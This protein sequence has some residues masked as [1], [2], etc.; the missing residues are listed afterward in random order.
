MD[1]INALKKAV[2]HF[3]RI[4]VALIPLGFLGIF[5]FYPLAGIFF[6]SF[7]QNHGF[8]LASFMDLTGSER[9]AGII[10]FTL[11]Q[12]GVSTILTLAFALPCAYVMANYSFRAKKLIMVI[13]SIPFVLPTI[14]VAAA[15][16]ALIGDRG[17]V[18]GIHLEHSIAMIFLAHVFYNFSVVLR[19]TTGFWSFLQHQISEAASVLGASPFQVFLKITLPLLRPAI[20]ASAILVFIFCFSSFGVIL[21]LGGPGFSTVEVEIYRQAA[22]RFNL[23]A[24]AILSLFQICFTFGMMWLYTLLQKKIPTFTPQGEFQ[25][26]KL[27]HTLVAKIMVLA[28]VCFILLFCLGPM[29]ALIIK[30]FGF[31]GRFSLAFYQELFQ[32]TSG[33]LF[34]VSPVKAVS[35]SLLFAVATLAMAV[36]V[37]VCAALTIQKN[38]NRLGSILDPVFMLPLSTSAVT[39][40][41]GIIITLDRPPLNLR[42]SV[43]LVPIAH[44][45]VAFPFVVRSVLPAV[46]SIPDSLREAA[47]LLG[48]TAARVWF[49]V[50]LPIMARAVTA[51]A[52]FAFTM[53][54]G[55]FGATLFIA[56]PEYAT[57]P[58]AIYRFLGQPGTMNYGQAMAVSSML[59]VVTAGGF[60][61]IEGFRSFGKGDNNTGGF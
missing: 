22:H 4:L 1:R 3:P 17:L 12:A 18:G 42:T 26:L 11:W 10:W 45:L 53:S 56:R 34:Y 5:Y 55:E 46:S 30:S 50:D 36:V 31:E 49:H 57:M 35:N 48:A 7:F 6:R 20:A 60:F 44:T 33:S 51:G 16:Q 58:V 43:M 14:V 29:A 9:I 32:N 52:M 28:C 37:G 59:M 40:G 2:S 39:L 41:F 27:P 24:A 47:S 54:L 13:A 38:K 19:I 8:S 25:S 61:L 23:S 15:F 21:V